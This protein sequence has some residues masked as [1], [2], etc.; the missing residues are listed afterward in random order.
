MNEFVPLLSQGKTLPPGDEPSPPGDEPSPPGGNTLAPVLTTTIEKHVPITS[1]AFHPTAPFLASNSIENNNLAT[2]FKLEK[3]EKGWSDFGSS[4]KWNFSNIRYI[5]GTSSS[6][7][8]HPTKP[9][10]ATGGFNKSDGTGDLCS[11]NLLALNLDNDLD[12]DKFYKISCKPLWGHHAPVTSVAFDPT[13]A[14]L[15]TGSD[16]KTVR[17]WLLSHDNLSANCVATLEGHIGA[18]QSVAFHPTANP[19]L[20]ATG[21]WDFTAR[22]WCF[23]S[24]GSN[25]SCVA[26]LEKHGGSVYSVA[27]H[28]TA[29]PSLLATG[30]LDTTVRLWRFLPNDSYAWY[31]TC[32]ATL[33]GH[34]GAVYSVAFHPMAPLLATGSYDGT[35]KLWRLYSDNT[36]ATCAR[37][38]NNSNKGTAKGHSNAVYSVAFHP[39]EP[40]LATGDTNVK[41]WKIKNTLES[42]KVSAGGSIIRHHKKRS[43]R[44]LKRYASKRIKRNRNRNKNK[45]R[46][47]KKAKTK[48]YRN[49]M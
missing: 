30:S 29:K 49:L 25:A 46:K 41:L 23:S 9:L 38:I 14:L 39:T 40:L 2:V 47:S 21:S 4:T 6:V 7:A 12:N 45:Y 42:L 18:V 33:K 5:P 34:S 17:L 22:L 28:P 19:P 32:V 13:G 11:A 8:F 48:R 44:K 43:S 16:D 26:T 1:M 20:L 24:D 10:L 37:T 3:I 36:M 15:A 27:F 31:A 35:A